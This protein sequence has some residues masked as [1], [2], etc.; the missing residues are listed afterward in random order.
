MTATGVDALLPLLVSDPGRPRL[1]WYG[2]DGERVELSGAV[3]VNWVHKTANLLVDELDGGPGTVL[4]LDLPPHW[5]TLVWALAAWRTGTTV[6]PGDATAGGGVD[7]LVTDRPVAGGDGAEGRAGALVV[8]QPLPALARR[9]D[10]PLP[11]GVLDAGPAVMG[12]GDALGWVPPAEP[13]RPALL[14]DG[15]TFADLP[16]AATAARPGAPRDRVLVRPGTARDAAAT[17]ALLLAALGVWADGGSLV[18]LVPGADAATR[19]D[20]LDR[21]VAAERVDLVVDLPR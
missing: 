19:D 12:S 13:A 21:L 17:T 16:A 11:V 18:L 8:A 7:V 4:A 2:G 9:W 15:P 1:T 20:A 3:L 10:G 14:P 5:R 6:A